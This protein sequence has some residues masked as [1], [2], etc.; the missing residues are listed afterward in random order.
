M[1][2]PV[3]RRKRDNAERPE[4]YY[5]AGV[6]GRKT[7]ITLPQ[8]ARD[9]HGIEDLDGIF[10]S[11][12][13]VAS[14][15]EKRQQRNGNKS[16]TSEDMEIAHSGS[17]PDPTEVLST[18]RSMLKSSKTTFP[19]PMGRSPHK[20]NIG[21]SPRRQS[22]VKPKRVDGNL[23]PLLPRP[24]VTRRLDFSAAEDARTLNQA[25]R[26]ENLAKTDI[27]ALE[28]TDEE[29]ERD[30]TEPEL[31]LRNE[32]SMEL[33]EQ[34]DYDPLLVLDDASEIHQIS[35]PTRRKST[36]VSMERQREAS[37][38]YSAEAVGG[39]DVEDAV[40][41]SSSK[42]KGKAPARESPQA[43]KS[44][45]TTKSL[46]RRG[47]KAQLLSSKLQTTSKR[48]ISADESVVETSY[49]DSPTQQTVSRGRNKNTARG[50]QLPTPDDTQPAADEPIETT[51]LDE[52]RTELPPIDRTVKKRGRPA[53]R[54]M[55]V[56][57]DTEQDVP[58]TTETG[59]ASEAEQRA[60]KRAKHSRKK[61]TKTGTPKERDP[62][63]S[64]FK[65]PEIPPKTGTGSRWDES[66]WASSRN[67]S[68]LRDP[69]PSAEA[70]VGR[71]RSGRQV[72]KPLNHFANE[73][74]QYGRDG[75]LLAVQTAETVERQV[76]SRSRSRASKRASSK[77]PSRRAA[78]RAR[79]G[80][81]ETIME[82]D[83]ESDSV[84]ME[85]WEASGEMIH[86]EVND[87]DPLR[88]TATD[89]YFETELAWGPNSVPLLPVHSAKFGFAKLLS[90]P[91]FGSGLMDFP[92]G[93]Y[94]KPR[95]SGKT[96][97]HAFVH[98]GKVFV[99]ISGRT[100]FMV[101]KGGSFHV[102]RGNL[103]EIQNVANVPARLFFAQG[104]EIV[105][106]E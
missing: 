11:P 103:Y 75:T 7:G 106:S 46:Q 65:K 76:T 53:K 99:R 25:A 4:N 30:T 86:G 24:T 48:N 58:A 81:D 91:Y 41:A 3:G 95:N 51:E 85:E 35:S 19:P 61:T 78:S 52:T 66:M 1:P 57:E 22:S 17:A 8:G 102:P 6:Q 92:V 77:A 10:S 97:L 74:A 90:M 105:V 72:I 26:S 49:V 80:V 55:E 42:Q 23:E 84:E 2:G 98:T 101:S 68:R 69:T 38:L 79:S 33:L 62:N 20:T 18:R 93:G 15:P 36:K 100:E 37:Q 14:S 12:E 39:E 96:S 27:Y 21:S 59:K 43:V 9:E 94:K 83:G 70:L 60:A 40:S 54:K 45:A 28:A 56:H 16:L 31:P 67:M 13:K 50:R 44:T 89:E 29:G 63:V 104:M 32:E 87:Y 5:E 47:G 82:D 71:T 34:G 73:R 64:S 88:G